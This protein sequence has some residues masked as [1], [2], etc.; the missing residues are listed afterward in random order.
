VDPYAASDPAEVDDPFLHIELDSLRSARS[1]YLALARDLRQ[2]ADALTL[3]VDEIAPGSTTAG[4]EASAA[5]AGIAEDLPGYAGVFEQAAEATGR[6]IEAVVEYRLE[7]HVPHQRKVL[8]AEEDAERRRSEAHIVLVGQP[9]ALAASLGEIDTWL[10]DE[11]RRFDDDFHA[12][13]DVLRSQ[14]TTFALRMSEL[15]L[16]G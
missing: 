9:E 15:A 6:L 2:Q 11:R 5:A 12:H 8:A 1:T 7:V 16:P 13:Q 10:S 4:T 3:L 14:V